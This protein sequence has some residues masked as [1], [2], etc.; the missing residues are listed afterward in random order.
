MKAAVKPV[1]V[2]WG[3]ALWLAAMLAWYYFSF[4]LAFIRA[5]SE[6]LNRL[7]TVLFPNGGVS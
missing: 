7:L 5:N 4:S 1:I 6:A 3:L 2:R